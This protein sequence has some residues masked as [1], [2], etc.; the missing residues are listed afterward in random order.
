[1]K[2]LNESLDWRKTGGWI[3]IATVLLTSA[4]LNATLPSADGGPPIVV[5]DVHTHVFNAH[6]LPL[7]GI[8]NARGARLGVSEI[9]AK[10]INAWVAHD[11]ID[12][13]LPDMAALSLEPAAVRR[14]V[15]G[16]LRSSVPAGPGNDLF[17]P[18]SVE[19]R[20]E[21]LEFVG[22]APPGTQ[23]GPPSQPGAPPQVQE[24]EIVARALQKL[25]FPPP[26]T[27]SLNTPEGVGAPR[28]G[29]DGYLGFLGVMLKGNLRIARLLEA[30]E[31]PQVDLF[32]CH[33]MDMEKSY[34]A[35]PVVPF[36]EQ[37]VRMG[38]LDARLAGKLL[39]FVAF[40]PFR[41]QDSLESVKR[42]L[43]S[44]AVGVKF[45]PPSGYRATGNELP[46]RP[47]VFK[48]GQRKR[49]DSRYAGLS[50]VEIIQLNDGLFSYAESIDVPIFSHCTPSGFEAESGYGLMADPK[51]WRRVLEKHPNLRLCLGHSGG[52]DYWLPSANP[53]AEEQAR[54]AFGAEV[55]ELCLKY[56]NVFCEV[57]YLERV[58][59]AGSRARFK[60]RLQSVINRPSPNA[61]WRFGD[62]IMYGTDWHMIYKENG[63]QSF[64]DIFAQLFRDDTLKPWTRSFFAANAIS[65]LRLEQISDKESFSEAQRRAW[66]QLVEAATKHESP[67][68]TGTP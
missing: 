18:L 12:D 50:A 62:K 30:K 53:T 56:R 2:A 45:Y 20:N 24:L 1:M 16:E 27:Q 48:P 66:K 13:P 6:D 32:V 41:R 54:A 35:R 51:Y 14:D 11:D 44:G 68:A 17:A 58:L 31:Y 60:T 63:H 19:E 67:A 15:L 55:V 34:A 37:M 59:D 9:L 43:R 47:S 26:E 52:D 57:G 38:K 5:I 7:A 33:M 49:W 4:R 40:D 29:I 61:E 8:L 39:H 21:L 64:P 23:V 10:L 28:G 3:V 65:Y 22:E 42:G 36:E 25:D 46:P